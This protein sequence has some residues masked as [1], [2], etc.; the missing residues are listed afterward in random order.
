VFVCTETYCIQPAVCLSTTNT[1]PIQSQF[2]QSTML[3]PTALT[4]LIVLV[5]VCAHTHVVH[6]GSNVAEMPTLSNTDDIEFY[7]I[8]TSLPFNTPSNIRYGI[9]AKRSTTGGSSSSRSVRVCVCVCS[10]NARAT[11]TRM[12]PYYL[13]LERLRGRSSLTT[14]PTTPAW[15]CG[16]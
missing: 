6:A 3:F 8:E 12:Y 13:Y 10:Y 16:T 9:T 7:Y 4:V 15:G 1:I 5:Y 11:L 14:A 2:D